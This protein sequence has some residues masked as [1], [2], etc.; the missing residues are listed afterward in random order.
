MRKEYAGEDVSELMPFF[1]TVSTPEVNMMVV[2]SE[3]YAFPNEFRTFFSTVTMFSSALDRSN[4]SED[5]T[6]TWTSSSTDRFLLPDM[7]PIMPIVGAQAW[8]DNMKTSK[9]LINIR[10]QQ[11]ALFSRLFLLT[12]YA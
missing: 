4:G 11:D 8:S 7:L 5:V 1:C 6:M 2:R 12:A 10:R 3:Y 9:G